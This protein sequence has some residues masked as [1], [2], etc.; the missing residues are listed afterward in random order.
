MGTRLGGGGS[1]RKKLVGEVVLGR[2]REG[3]GKGVWEAVWEG[4]GTL[5][6]SRRGR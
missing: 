2:G 6:K 4:V 3:G 5:E 1:I